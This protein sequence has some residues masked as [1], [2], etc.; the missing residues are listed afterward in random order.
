VPWSTWGPDE[1]IAAASVTNA[2]LVFVLVAAT[3]FYAKRTSD[4]VTELREARIIETLPVLHW[5]RHPG[6]AGAG[7]RASGTGVE[8]NLALLLTNYGRG[9]ARLLAFEAT[10]DDG[11][12][13]I[14]PELAVPSTMAPGVRI[15]LRLTQQRPIATFPGRRV[16]RIALRFADAHEL[17]NYE[18][19]PVVTATWPAQGNSE[20]LEFD[21]DERSPKQRRVKS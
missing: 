18:T 21:A 7:Y 13:M 5:Q 11:T 8:I 19:R 20:I 2:V 1:W 17:R 16:V 9:P 12:A 14:A 10:M 15:E 4:T 3:I 6:S